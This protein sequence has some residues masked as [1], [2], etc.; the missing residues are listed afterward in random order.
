VVERL[1]FSNVGRTLLSAALPRGVPGESDLAYP[2]W[3]MVVFTIAFALAVYWRK[4]SEFH[5]RLILIACCALTAAA[6]GRFPPNLLPPDHAR[7]TS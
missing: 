5:R 1:G 2:L 6:F 4:K 3:D 7:S